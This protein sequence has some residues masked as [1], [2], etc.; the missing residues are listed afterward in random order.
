VLLGYAVLGLVWLFTGDLVENAVLLLLHYRPALSGALG[1]DRLVL[2]G[3]R[4]RKGHPPSPLALADEHA[5]GVGVVG[6]VGGVGA[7]AAG[8]EG[9]SSSSAGG[10]GDEERGRGGDGDRGDGGLAARLGARSPSPAPPSLPSPEPTANLFSPLPP[11]PRRVPS[12]PFGSTPSVAGVQGQAGGASERADGALTFALG[13]ARPPPPS[14]TTRD[15]IP[16]TPHSSA[17]LGVSDR[18]RSSSLTSPAISPRAAESDGRGR[19]FSDGDAN[20]TPSTPLPRP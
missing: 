14:L 17:R 5:G 8:G 16:P 3:V 12:T 13:D 7:G 4:L 11:P 10:G 15:L 20:P 18:S 1:P 19:V 6:G 9:E 2:F